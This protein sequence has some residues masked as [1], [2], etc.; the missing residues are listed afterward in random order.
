MLLVASLMSLSIP[1]A[2]LHEYEQATGLDSV[3]R[4]II[5]IATYP[6][7]VYRQTA[8]C[9]GWRPLRNFGN[10][11]EARDE[12][13]LDWTRSYA[14]TPSCNSGGLPQRA[15]WRLGTRV[16]MLPGVHVYVRACV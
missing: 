8:I 15:G 7:P 6:L 13:H 3:W 4:A 10:L 1:V 12:Y 11:Q 5:C 2:P 16:C 9:D 14:G